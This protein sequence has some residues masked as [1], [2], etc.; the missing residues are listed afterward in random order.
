MKKL[1]LTSLFYL[2]LL[3]PTKLVFAAAPDLTIGSGTGQPGQTITIPITA[4]LSIPVYSYQFTVTYDPS[5]LTPVS[6]TTGSADAN[7][8][9]DDNPNTPGTLVVGSFLTTATGTLSGSAQQIAV[10]NF[11]VNATPKATLATPNLNLSA[12]WFDNTAITAFTNGTF[13]LSVIGDV[14]VDGKITENDAVLVLKYILGLG[15]LTPAQMAVADVN[16][17]GKVTLID[18][19]EIEEY[20]IGDLK[21]F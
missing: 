15:T 5:L 1:I 10:I 8:F 9:I 11:T 16:K 19:A 2:L 17:D 13:S 20:A 4:D 7:W 6:V 18:S 14:D 12:A 3:I 21:S